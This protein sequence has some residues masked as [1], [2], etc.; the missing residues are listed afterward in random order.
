MCILCLY[1]V[2][3]CEDFAINLV[4][5]WQLQRTDFWWNIQMQYNCLCCENDLVII[6]L[7]EIYDQFMLKYI[8]N[9][10]SYTH[11]TFYIWRNK[12]NIWIKHWSVIDDVMKWHLWLDHSDLQ[13]LE[14][15]ASAS[16]NVQIKEIK[17]KSEWIKD[18]KTV[19]CDMYEI[20]KV[21]CWIWWESREFKLKSEAQLAL[22]FH[23][24]EE[25][26]DEYN[27][28]LL[29]TDCWSE[30]MWDY[31][32]TDQ[33]SEI[34]LAALKHLFRILKHQYQLHSQKIECDNEIYMKCKIVLIWL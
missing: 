27:C 32:L 23:E 28:Q 9:D 6:Y 12:F 10:H 18:I 14:H 26:F 34:I 2:V 7:Q 25:E 3:Y 20:F 17:S 22:D 5:F 30:F 24:Y 33:K 13:T 4:S 29:I 8:L 15:L 1:D 31:Y 19:N 11:M 21:K 16:K